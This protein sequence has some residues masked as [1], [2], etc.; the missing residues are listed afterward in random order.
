MQT[1]K[2]LR[3]KKLVSNRSY[4][5]G[6]PADVDLVRSIGRL[7]LVGLSVCECL[8]KRMDSCR[9]ESLLYRSLVHQSCERAPR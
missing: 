1:Q 6:L 5:R 9:S 7:Y 2:E 3:L 8:S 4:I